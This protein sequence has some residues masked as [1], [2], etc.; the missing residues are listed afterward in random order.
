MND[1]ILSYAD[2]Y[3]QN[4]DKTGASK[5]MASLSRKIP[6]DLPV[7]K[8]DEIRQ[9]A[10]DTFKA[11]GCSGVVRIDFMIERTIKNNIAPLLDGSTSY[12]F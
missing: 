2:K 8:S 5:G 4:A 7:D 1:E 10:V 12:R 11:L 9:L 3:L 6:A